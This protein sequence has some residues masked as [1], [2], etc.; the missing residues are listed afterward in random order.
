[1]EDTLTRFVSDLV[2]R[3]HGPFSFRFVLQ[4]LIAVIYAARDGLADA[5][6]GRPPYFWTL[7][8]RPD[9]RR[10]M[11]REGWKA[12]TRVMVLGV[13]MDTTY[14]V[15]EFRR[16]HPLQMTVIVLGLAFVP[17]VLLRGPIGRIATWWTTRTAESEHHLHDSLEQL[18]AGDHGQRKRRQRQHR[19]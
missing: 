13:V 5:R 15:I 11:L 4:P 14:Q 6:E 17:Y 19:E 3:L 18:A 7:F 12:V 9:Q 1:M 8:A 10:Q 2:G 16:I